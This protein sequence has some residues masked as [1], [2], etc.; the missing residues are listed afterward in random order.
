MNVEHL[1]RDKGRRIIS[2]RPQLMLS[3]A[4]ASLSLHRIG[5]LIVS[6]ED[7]PILGILSERDIVWAVAARGASALKETISDNMTRE[8]VVCTRAA[9]TNEVM[10][11]MTINKFRHMPVVEN[12]VLLGIVSIGDIVK[13]RIAEV[14]AETEEMREY[15]AKAG[16]MPRS[17]GL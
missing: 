11:Q 10:E 9:T 2:I 13:H 14:E 7:H 3:D 4:A 16:E 15:I 5:A 12:G 8:V 17:K 6:D 1:L